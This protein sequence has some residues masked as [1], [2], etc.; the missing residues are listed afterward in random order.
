M[1]LTQRG[2]YAVTAMFDLALYQCEDAP[3]SLADI[4]ARQAIPGR[5]LQQLLHRLVRSGL[6]QGVRGPGGGYRLIGSPAAISIGHIVAAVG[7][8]LDA[9]R[10]AG[11]GDCQGGATCLTHHLWMDLN[12]EVYAFLSG[13]SLASLV[14]RNRNRVGDSAGVQQLRMAEAAL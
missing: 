11:R 5:Y 2:R 3:V 4:V 13:I 10:C 9:T 8:R 6:V 14:E 1:K 7:E 12:S